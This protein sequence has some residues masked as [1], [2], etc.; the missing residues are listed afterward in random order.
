M[1]R[2]LNKIDNLPDAINCGIQENFTQIPNDLL[3]NPNISSKAKILLSILL[4]N[5]YGWKS[6]IESLSSM[7]KEKK[8][9]ISASL[10]ELEKFG[11]LIRIRYRNKYNKKWIGSF[12]AYTNDPFKFN[13]ENQIKLLEHQNLEAIEPTTGKPISGLAT[14]GK[15]V[16]NNTNNNNTNLLRE[17][18]ENEDKKELITPKLFERFWN[19]YPKKVDKGKALK[20]W[21]DICTQK[22]KQSIRPEWSTVLRAIRSQIKTERWQNPQYIPHAST[23]LNQTRWIDDPNEMKSNNSPEKEFVLNDW[24]KLTHKERMKIAVEQSKILRD[25]PY[26]ENDYDVRYYLCPDGLYR[27]WN[28]EPF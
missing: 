10:H 19:I 6:C 28:G 21:N 22:S 2:G 24:V 27:G 7:V 17:E 14:T 16:T 18:D 3:K 13:Y 9:S 23:W 25:K 5:R 11:Y 12:W 8:D 26:K 20:S 15:S 4:S 1:Q